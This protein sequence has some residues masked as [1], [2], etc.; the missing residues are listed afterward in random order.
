MK[1][2]IFAMIVAFTLICSAAFGF[3]SCE[4]EEVD[5]AN[6][7]APEES[8]WI[9]YTISDT[10]KIVLLYDD[11]YRAWWGGWNV[12]GEWY[13]G[14]E[15]IRLCFNENTEYWGFLFSREGI[16]N[17][18][19]SGHQA[20]DFEMFAYFN[21]DGDVIGGPN[22][23][24]DCGDWLFDT[25]A[26]LLNST[27][28]IMRET[29]EVIPIQSISVE[30]AGEE[31]WDWIDLEGWD[32][33]RS[34]GEDTVYTIDL[35]NISYNPYRNMGEWRLEDRTVPIKIH[36]YEDI[37]SFAVY[38]LSDNGS[39]LVFIANLESLS[40]NSLRI[41]SASGNWYNESI[42]IKDVT[43]TKESQTETE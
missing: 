7:D 37:K 43:I 2:R 27:E 8:S 11:E 38:D 13:R 41:T 32:E 4:M 20:N 17:F 19:Y 24:L 40:E 16:S 36:F 12:Y 1:K 22:M 14:S 29:G 31:K 42:D 9:T 5:P 10:E 39:R 6:F 26:G 23:I 18:T 33:F 3:C 34:Y 15:T 28:I 25:N 30:P 35:L 21:I